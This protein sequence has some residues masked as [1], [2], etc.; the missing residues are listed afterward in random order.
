MI[1]YSKFTGNIGSENLTNTFCQSIDKCQK[2]CICVCVC[3]GGGGWV[4][5]G[6]GGGGEGMYIDCGDKMI[7][8]QIQSFYTRTDTSDEIKYSS[9]PK[10]T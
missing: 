1:K 4:G 9:I 8:I 7:Y 2:V 10:N 3:V 5:G 6:V